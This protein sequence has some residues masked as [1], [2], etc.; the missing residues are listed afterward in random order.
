MSHESRPLYSPDAQ[1]LAFVSERTGGGHTLSLKIGV[2]NQVTTVDGFKR[3][4]AS[5]HDGRWLY[6]SSTSRDIA[7]MPDRQGQSLDRPSLTFWRSF[8]LAA[9]RIRCGSARGRH[10]V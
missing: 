7:C 3:L 9:G 5:S 4:D 10:F 6:F 8:Q 1:R 2:F